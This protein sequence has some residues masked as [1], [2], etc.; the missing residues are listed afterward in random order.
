MAHWPGA[1]VERQYR[2]RATRST[3]VGPFP[4]SEGDYFERNQ[5]RISRHGGGGYS[6]N[7][8]HTKTDP[9]GQSSPPLVQPSLPS[10]QPSVSPEIP[11]TG[12]PTDETP[13]LSMRDEDS[14]SDDNPDEDEEEN[15]NPAVTTRSVR[16]VRP[17]NRMNFNA[18][19]V[20]ELNARKSKNAKDLRKKLSS[21]KVRAR[22]LNHEFISSVKWTQLKKLYVYWTTWKAPW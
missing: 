10:E 19:K 14:D 22:V 4:V 12:D 11:I 9:T 3:A 17:P 13:P 21:Q 2:T 5:R 8:G 1:C 20:K 18:M 6:T 7:N 16:R 15:R